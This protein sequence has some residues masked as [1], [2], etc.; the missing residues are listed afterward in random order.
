M[1]DNSVA[2]MPCTT[3]IL[4]FG[5]PVRSDDGVGIYVI[6]QLHEKLADQSHISIFDMGT[7]AFEVLFK[8]KGTERILI[9]DAVKSEEDEVG[10]IYKVPG[11]EIEAPL[12]KQDPLVF[13]HSLKWDQALA[14]THKI[15]GDTFPKDVEVYLI[16]VNNTKLAEGL[17]EKVKNAADRLID[18]LLN[19]L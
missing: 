6:Q 18:T 16:G 1:N 19:E 9:I 14:Y 7:S 11:E 5:N 17:S 10:S 15:L 3:S 13:L 2:N 8:L 12:T 4:G